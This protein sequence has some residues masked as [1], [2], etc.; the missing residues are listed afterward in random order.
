MT[1]Q[2]EREYVIELNQDG[3]LHQLVQLHVPEHAGA[4]RSIRNCTGMPLSARFVAEAISA[5]ER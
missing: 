5:Q 2:D 1:A 4:I 3:Q